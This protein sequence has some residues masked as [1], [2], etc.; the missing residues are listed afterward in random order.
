MLSASEIN[1]LKQKIKTEMARRSGY[2]SLSSNG[3]YD[4]AVPGENINYAGAAFDFVEIPSSNGPVLK[5]HG[6]KTIDLLLRID[7][8]GNL[9]KTGDIGEKIS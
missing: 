9:E 1:T 4:Y 2:G 8:Y 6:E 5:E 7:D 3:G